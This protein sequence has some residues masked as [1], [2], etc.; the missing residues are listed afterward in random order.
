MSLVSRDG[1]LVPLSDDTVLAAGDEVLAQSEPG[2][3]WDAVFAHRRDDTE[4][5]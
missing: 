5:P 1:A 2:T 4:A 3:S